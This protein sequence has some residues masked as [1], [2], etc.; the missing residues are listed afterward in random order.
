M[1]EH[2]HDQESTILNFFYRLEINKTHINYVAKKFKSNS[3]VHSYISEFAK[4][5]R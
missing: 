2:C 1:T 4:I 5:K 3:L